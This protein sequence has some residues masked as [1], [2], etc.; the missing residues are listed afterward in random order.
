MKN[1]TEVVAHAEQT[2][3]KKQKP[4]DAPLDSIVVEKVD[5]E[6]QHFTSKFDHWT[7]ILK[8]S[9]ISEYSN[10]RAVF[11]QEI[12]A[13]INQLKDTHKQEISALESKLT[14]ADQKAASATSKQIQK[15][16]LV[17]N[18]IIFTQKRV[19]TINQNK[20][21]TLSKCFSYWKSRASDNYYLNVTIKLARSYHTRQFH[22][23]ILRKWLAEAR[24]SWRQTIE[25][26]VRVQ[27]IN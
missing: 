7:T 11:Q 17:E 14:E 21:L 1:P 26:S 12:N 3:P 6:L 5:R 19:S 4:D 9:L 27:I 22:R 18:M 25:R 8:A 24:S 16:K 10:T 20:K 13:D 15:S 2:E 23:K